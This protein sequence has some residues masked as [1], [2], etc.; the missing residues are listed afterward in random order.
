MKKDTALA[1]LNF[2]YGQR[3]R[4]SEKEAS[5][6][7]SW[8]VKRLVCEDWASH[9]GQ[10]GGRFGR[11]HEMKSSLSIMSEWEAELGLAQILQM[12]AH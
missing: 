1:A 6:Y 11:S 12:N 4:A 5:L 8:V 3:G 2:N 10:S 7:V 9:K